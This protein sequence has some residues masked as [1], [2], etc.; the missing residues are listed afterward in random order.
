M[1]IT[2]L[3]KINNVIV[4]KVKSCTPATYDLDS[5]KSARSARGI[6]TRDRINYVPNLEVEVGILTQEQ[7]QPL[8]QSLRGVSV[9]VEWFDPES[10]TYKTGDFYANNRNP[11][12]LSLDPVRYYPMKFTL[13]AFR[14]IGQ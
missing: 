4:P 7:M 8:L 11:E 10:G 2:Y 12:V 13:I 3:L 1:T 6:L 5:K 9:S 14:G